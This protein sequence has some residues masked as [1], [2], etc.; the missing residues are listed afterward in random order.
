M[1]ERALARLLCRF[2]LLSFH[3]EMAMADIQGGAKL[4]ESFCPA[5]ASHSCHARLVLSKTVPFFCTTLYT[6][7][8]QKKFSDMDV[9]GGAASENNPD[10]RARERAGTGQ[11][12]QQAKD[13]SNP[14]SSDRF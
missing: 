8:M 13:G 10:M 3:D 7:T 4:R 11:E 2:R 9:V 6:S 5:A 12:A 1:Q 14:C